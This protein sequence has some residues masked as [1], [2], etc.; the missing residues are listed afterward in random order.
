MTVFGSIYQD[1]KTVCMH[2]TKL[3]ALSKC[4]NCMTVTYTCKR[5]TSNEDS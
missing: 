3:Q 2:R 1:V 4:Q 5:E